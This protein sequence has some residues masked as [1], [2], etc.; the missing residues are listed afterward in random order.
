VD[1]ARKRSMSSGSRSLFF[2]KN[3]P[4]VYT[5]GYVYICEWALNQWNTSF[6]D[7]E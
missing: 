1:V 3:V 2:S 7:L 5:W 6:F 4:M